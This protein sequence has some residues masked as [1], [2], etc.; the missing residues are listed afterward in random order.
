MVLLTGPVGGTCQRFIKL[1]TQMH[2][3]ILRSL[4]CVWMDG[5]RVACYNAILSRRGGWGGGAASAAASAA[6]AAADAAAADAASDA[7]APDSAATD[8]AAEDD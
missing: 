3:Q 5:T 4:R 2:M 6:A 7:A 1:Q 8:S